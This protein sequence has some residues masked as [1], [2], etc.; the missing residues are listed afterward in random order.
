MTYR[1]D[2]ENDDTVPADRGLRTR[3]VCLETENLS[4]SI[5]AHCR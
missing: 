4:G 2:H 1:H 5:M 3:M